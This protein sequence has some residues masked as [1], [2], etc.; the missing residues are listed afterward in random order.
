MPKPKN[1][2]TFS[3]GSKIAE[4]HLDLLMDEFYRTYSKESQ[5]VNYIFDFSQV[6]WIANEEL[7]VLTGLFKSLVDSGTN[8]KVCFLINGSSESINGRRARQFVQLWEVW[9][10][11]SIV[12]HRD[13][14]SYFDIDGRTID[15]LKSQFK[16]T[17]VSKEIYESYG[18]TPFV[19]LEYIGSYDDRR[20]I[21]KLTDT[22]KLEAATSEILQE[23]NCYL[24]FHN[25]TLSSIVTKEL[26]E[27]FLDHYTESIFGPES[28]Q[29]FLSL[30]LK[31]KLDEKRLG[32][33]KVQS[34]LKRNFEEEALPETRSFFVEK[35]SSNLFSNRS[36]LQLSFVDFGEGIPSTLKS[37]FLKNNGEGYSHRFKD[38]NQD[39][40]ILEYAFKHNSSQ[41]ELL[42]KY[43]DEFAVP[44]GLFDLLSIVK[45][46]EGLIIARSRY[47]KIALDFSHGKTIKESIIYFGQQSTFF[48][49]TLFTIYIPERKL[50]SDIDSTSIKPYASLNNYSFE[51]ENY[52]HISLF[53][54]QLV[55]KSKDHGKKGFYNKLFSSFL[56]GIKSNTESLV[57]LDFTGWEIDERVTKK[58]I[59]FLCTD[60]SVNLKNNVIAIN[61]P[62]K[63]FLAS[64]KNELLSLSEVDRKFKIHPTP[65]IYFDTKELEIFWLGVFSE[66]DIVKLN[67]LLYENH[68]L[69]KS[70]FENP[71]DIV[72]HI[73]HYDTY[74][75]L[76]SV[77]DSAKL[78]AHFSNQALV[79]ETKDIEKIIAPCIK[80]EKN[81]IFLCNGNYYQNEYL[82]LFDALSDKDSQVYLTKILFRRIHESVG[83]LNNF[84]FV[85]ITSSS[86]KLIEY[87]ESEL[88]GKEAKFI[89][90]NNYFSFE[91]EVSFKHGIEKGTKVI[92]L[93]DVIST[94]F[95]V[96][97]VISHLSLVGATLERIGV[98]VNS[99]DNSFKSFINQ[100]AEILDR[101]VSV[102]HRPLKKF[103]RADISNKLKEEGLGVIRINPFTNTPIVRK[104]NQSNYGE[105]VLL[106][107]KEFVELIS[108]D[109]IRVGYFNYNNLVHPY[110]FDMHSI[111]K[112]RKASE[113]IN[114]KIFK[115]LEKHTSLKG[116]EIIFYPKTSGIGNIDFQFMKD[117]IFK[118]HKVKFYELERFLTNEGWRFPPPFQSLFNLSKGRN[119]MILDDGSCSGESISQ[120]IDEVAFLNVRSI[121]VLSMIGRLNDHKREFFSRIKKI[122][123][124][125]ENIPVNIFFGSNWHI[126]TYHLSKSP[127]I[128]ENKWLDQL[129]EL[130]NVPQA[131]KSLVKTI[132]HE[133]TPRDISESNSLYL[134]RNKNGSPIYDEMALVRNEFGKISEYRFYREYF[135]FFD[136]FIAYHESKKSRDRGEHPY[137]KI[138]TVCAVFLHEPYLYNK[139]I[140]VIPDIIDRIEEFVKLF[141]IDQKIPEDKLCYNWNKKDMIHLL[142]ITFK[143]E[144]LLKILNPKN[145]KKLLIFLSDSQSTVNYLLYKLLK[146]FPLNKTESSIKRYDNQIKELLQ[147]VK[148]GD[149]Q[150][151]KQVKK[152]YNFLKTLPS[153]TDIESHLRILKENYDKEK[154]PELHDGKISFNHNVSLILGQ[155]RKAMDKIESGDNIPKELSD[156]IAKTWFQLMNFITPILTFSIT[157]EDYLAP[158]PY[159]RLIK[160]TE[161]DSDSLRSLVGINQDLIF[162]LKESFKDIDK[163]KL[164]EKNIVQIQANFSLNTEFHELI[165]N[166]NT[167]WNDFMTN[168]IK[169]LRKLNTECDFDIEEV[170][171]SKKVK[172]PKIYSQKL[173]INELIT[174][175]ENH[176]KVD[177]KVKVKI[178]IKKLY[179]NKVQIEIINPIADI[180]YSNSNG[181][182]TKCLILLASSGYFGFNYNFRIDDEQYHQKLK[183]ELI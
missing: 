127:V 174:N 154:A 87:F 120:M 152:F 85:G 35:E 156:L 166:R 125:D 63:P 122:N 183:F 142:F 137:K 61:P 45:R 13:F 158:Y 77:I 100:G 38:Q 89:R 39:T 121:I 50:E 75:N 70:D 151:D 24:P 161:R 82:Q 69:R 76:I 163:L 32:K 103:T 168:F 81:S 3:L 9:K 93:C 106:S 11:Y 136:E 10:I 123:S 12:P 71:D 130:P 46:F 59:F 67:E 37:A 167:D 4:Q 55:Q 116:I 29:A 139:V 176:C 144:N 86:H 47:G 133:I 179:S 66:K 78:R 83:N 134:L 15:R 177:D 169:K 104:I 107:N 8:F 165:E 6:E 48:P 16:I 53:D 54:I 5:S 126:P 90:L 95:M 112:N 72:G 84:V 1:Q 92:L 102:Y 140:V 74:G 119:V 73:N 141:V 41:H 160:F 58:I 27:N 19:A 25:E 171:G 98:L 43:K 97:R 135:K 57:Y 34:I 18:V 26:Y 164:I 23:N 147:E 56:E 153:R 42:E 128:E 17:S 175:L 108:V 111:L 7:L 131:I 159:F 21:E 51:K 91:E 146:Y 118:S 22:Y 68:D 88:E 113:K 157:F 145:L 132:K 181:E 150:L 33:N 65:F 99:M 60:Y 115:A 36:L 129:I 31:K 28:N 62:S 178:R 155:V 49:G 96:E 2:I 110:F 148:T 173:I 124:G 105:S 40:Q 101:L 52:K 14:N 64:I 182:G 117:E 30:V 80:S 143:E 170:Q 114:T 172:V 180:S 109:Q 20:I 79:V 162:S 149:D 44:R 94:G 138:E